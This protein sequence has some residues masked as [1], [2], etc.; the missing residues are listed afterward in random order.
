MIVRDHN[1]SFAVAPPHL[2]EETDQLSRARA[3][4][5]AG[6]LIGQ[7]DLRFIG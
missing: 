1:D 4:E 2:V 7:Q 3:V 5:V 6:R